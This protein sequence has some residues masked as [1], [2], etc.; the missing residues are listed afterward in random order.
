[1]EIGPVTS[2]REPEIDESRPQHENRPAVRQNPLAHENKCRYLRCRNTPTV[3][4][5]KGP[6]C[7]DH[8]DEYMHEC[9]SE[10]CKDHPEYTIHNGCLIQK[11]FVND[12]HGCV[13][14]YAK[15]QGMSCSCMD[16]PHQR[17]E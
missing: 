11:R 9:M 10:F 8:Y 17:D 1:M 16:D 6:V 5:E 3:F 15:N 4:T 14:E 13:E 2:T 12:C 7:L